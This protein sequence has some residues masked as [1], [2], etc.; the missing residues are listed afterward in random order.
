MDLL[1]R[2]NWKFSIS[3]INHWIG[4]GQNRGTQRA[5]WGVRFV[6]S[7]SYRTRYQIPKQAPSKEPSKWLWAIADVLRPTFRPGL[8]KAD[9]YVASESTKEDASESMSQKAAMTNAFSYHETVEVE[10]L[11][12]F[13]LIMLVRTLPTSHV[14]FSCRII[15]LS[16]N[17]FPKNDTRAS[18]ILHGVCNNNNHTIPSFPLSRLGPCFSRTQPS[19]RTG[20]SRDNLSSRSRVRSQN[21]G[22]VPRDS[23][24]WRS[25]RLPK[26]DPQY[27]LRIFARMF[28]DYHHFPCWRN[29]DR[30]CKHTMIIPWSGEIPGLLL[31]EFM[32]TWPGL[33]IWYPMKY[34]HGK[35]ISDIPWYSHGFLMIIP[36]YVPL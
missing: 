23:Q 32:L 25:Q 8:W 28:N 6:G 22:H 11:V 14:M 24:L 27:Y 4:V 15:N 10:A 21:R 2:G 9:V 36:L 7:V 29:H 26:I 13:R 3:G 30:K 33:C 16:E 18:Y 17:N 20:S 5:F 12:S 19:L 35:F 34:P 31:V 1:H